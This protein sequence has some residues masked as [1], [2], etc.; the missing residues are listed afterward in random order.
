VAIRCQKS[1]EVDDD[2]E[3]VAIQPPAAAESKDDVDDEE[4]SDDSSEEESE[5]EPVKA[6]NAKKGKGK[7][8][9]KSAKKGPAKGPK[10]AISSDAKPVEKRI[11][12]AKLLQKEVYEDGTMRTFYPFVEKPDYHLDALAVQVIVNEALHLAGYGKG[13]DAWLKTVIKLRKQKDPI[14]LTP[15]PQCITFMSSLCIQ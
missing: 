15:S 9:K 11:K 5:D 7:P 6:K 10:Q 8:V 14:N 4:F 3:V 12:W 2:D 1:L 13:K